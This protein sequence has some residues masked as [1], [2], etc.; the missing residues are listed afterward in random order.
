M[1][2]PADSRVA[3]AIGA[4]DEGMV[5]VN[6]TA[7]V[8]SAGAPSPSPRRPG[9]ETVLTF[10]NGVLASVASLYIGTHSLTVTIIAVAMAVILAALVLIFRR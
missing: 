4:L 1:V 8:P 6:E 9:P 5:G 2:M 3:G 10:V 7:A